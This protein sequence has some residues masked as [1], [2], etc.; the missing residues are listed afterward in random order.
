MSYRIEQ[1]R[2]KHIYVYE[3]ESYWDKEKKQPRQRRTYIGKKDPRTGEIIPPKKRK[4]GP[5]IRVKEEG[6]IALV[7]GE[8]ERLG[9]TA[10][11]R[12]IYGEQAEHISHLVWYEVIEGRALSHY[13]GWS[14]GV[15]IGEG[16]R[17]ST[18]K[19]Y[20]VVEEV[21]RDEEKQKAFISGWMK[22]WE[23]K[24]RGVYYDITSISSYGEGYEEMEWGYNRDGE[25]LRQ[26]NY[27]LVVGMPM[28][29]PLS[30]WTY[31]GG[32]PDVVSLE[33]FLREVR[34][35]IGREV[36]VVMDRGFYSG[37]RLQELVEEGYGVVVA[38]PWRL[39]VSQELYRRHRH[40]LLSPST[41]RAY[42]GGIVHMMSKRVEL[43]WG[44]VD[45]HVYMN[46]ASHTARK[47]T[48]YQRMI[49]VERWAREYEGEGLARF[50]KRFREEYP[51]MVSYF[52]VTERNGRI[53]L[54]RRV[55]KIQADIERMGVMMVASSV[56]G[57][58]S[59]EVLALYRH[60]DRV[61]KLFSTLKHELAGR[62]L[63]AHRRWTI[64]GRIFIHF[65]SLILTCSLK[66]KL[67]ASSLPSKWTLQD[68]FYQ[69]RKVKRVYERDGNSYFLPLSKKTKDIFIQFG[70]EAPKT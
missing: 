23:K 51:H 49:D 2:G 3:V 57:L 46:E 25:L 67:D 33:R 63:R 28:G 58:P 30:Y 70:L 19:V 43:A 54:R 16:E 64:Q 7:K 9:L 5:V 15:G 65:L 45:V 36:W 52:N 18:S 26:I 61:E 12:E 21:G 42:E 56:P 27:G 22:R 10:L 20:E 8:S 38:L 47:E 24:V 6:A 69:L 66:K 68:V 13:E 40:A 31:S 17:M 44:E 29:L 35:K 53:I 14:E 59:D 11:L 34:G 62:R 32:I 60:K 4:R 1:R 41:A 39:K 48:F 37:E 50:M 55:R